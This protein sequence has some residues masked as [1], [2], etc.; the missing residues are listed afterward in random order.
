MSTLEQDIERLGAT[1]NRIADERNALLEVVKE[2]GAWM[3]H[4]LEHGPIKSIQPDDAGGPYNQHPSGY[5]A[6]LVP[7][8]DMRQKLAM[9]QETLVS[10]AATP[11]AEDD[12]EQ[13]RRG[14]RDSLLSPGSNRSGVRAVAHEST[15][16]PQLWTTER[17]SD[18]RRTAAHETGARP[19][20]KS[21][22]ED[23]IDR[24]RRGQS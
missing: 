18:P 1:A 10:L 2:L 16:L 5:A 12:I 19:E 21:D 15:S 23:E 14:H 7:D 4:K 20:A 24:S 6:V 8:W 22:P 11:T 13:A 3:K 9:I 17:Q